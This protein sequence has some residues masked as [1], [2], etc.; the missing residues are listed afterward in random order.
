MTEP[1]SWGSGCGPLPARSLPAGTGTDLCAGGNGNTFQPVQSFVL[2]TSRAKS[3]LS[4]KS[5]SINLH[6]MACN[7][8]RKKT[9]VRARNCPPGSC[10]CVYYLDHT[11]PGIRVS[12]L[13]VSWVVLEYSIKSDL[14]STEAE[15]T[16]L[17]WG[18]ALAQCA[19]LNLLG[20]LPQDFLCIPRMQD[21]TSSQVKQ[22]SSLSHALT[23]QCR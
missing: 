21:H 5:G 23:A 22:T 18:P 14:S 17:S 20:L 8:E 19:S 16:F 12:L 3:S 2:F 1:A 9:T 15:D 11:L 13:A 6:N 7:T 10:T 4:V